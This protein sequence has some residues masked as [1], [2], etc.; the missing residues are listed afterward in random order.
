[1]LQLRLKRVKFLFETFGE[2]RNETPLLQRYFLIKSSLV[3][4]SKLG[5]DWLDNGSYD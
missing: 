3:D 4:H 1:M 2:K 5:H